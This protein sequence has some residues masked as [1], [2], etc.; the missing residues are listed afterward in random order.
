VATDALDPLPRLREHDAGIF[1]PRGSGLQ[2][3]EIGAAFEVQ[4][5]VIADGD[6]LRLTHQADDELLQAADPG[7]KVVDVHG[8]L[9]RVG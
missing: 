7:G 2:G 1:Q 5:G 4:Q 3:H 6:L 8:W 9:F